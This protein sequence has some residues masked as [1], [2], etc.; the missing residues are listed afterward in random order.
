MC[1]FSFVFAYVCISCYALQFA[2]TVARIPP[3]I[4]GTG[5]CFL[6][7]LPPHPCCCASSSIVAD[8]ILPARSEAFDTLSLVPGSGT[9]GSGGGARDTFPPILTQFQFVSL[10]V[11]FCKRTNGCG[12]A[13]RHLKS[14][15]IPDVIGLPFVSLFSFPANSIHIF[16]TVL[17]LYA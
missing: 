8:K 7:M 11:A 2:W 9:A 1:M 10:D 6:Y 13:N 12:R 16:G 17:W 5:V 14:E 15:S 4:G 3:D